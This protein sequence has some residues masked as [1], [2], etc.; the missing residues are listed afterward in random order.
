MNNAED[1]QMLDDLVEDFC[2]RAELYGCDSVQVLL[3][4]HSHKEGTEVIKIGRGNWYARQ[5]MAKEF[6]DADQARTG[7]HVRMEE[8]GGDD[9]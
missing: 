4:R 8:F 7:N 1:K 3:S 6:I 2:R 9:E 5:G